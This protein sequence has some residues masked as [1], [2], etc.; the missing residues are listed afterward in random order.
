MKFIGL[1][2][3]ANEDDILETVLKSHADIVDVFYVLDGTVPNDRS[4]AICEAHPKCGG[5]LTDNDLPHPPYPEKPVCG[6][7]QAIYEMAVRDHG[8]DNWFLILHG[9]EI[10][11]AHP[12]D[13]AATG[14][15]GYWFLLPFYFPRAG[16]PWDY[17][18][19]PLEQLRWSLGPGFPEFRMFKGAPGVKYQETQTY[20]TKPSGVDGS[21]RSSAPILHYLYRSPEAQRAR[22]AQHEASGFDPANYAHITARDEVYWTDEMIARYRAQDY[23][24]DLRCDGVAA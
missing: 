20:N 17:S 19:G 15:D 10:W 14:H 9:D 4:R 11:T 1:L 12:G 18:R 6:Y 16:E 3:V 8:P 22:A 23:F 7:R 5:Y 24:T 13:V 2:M 21:G